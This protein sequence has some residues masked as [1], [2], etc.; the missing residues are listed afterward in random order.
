MGVTLL[1]LFVLGAFVSGDGEIDTRPKRDD[2]EEPTAYPQAPPPEGLTIRPM[3]E[4]RSRATT[5][6]TAP[7]SGE[8]IVIPPVPPPRDG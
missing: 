7:P 6:S 8:T 1:V 4:T 5:V 2:D 3:A